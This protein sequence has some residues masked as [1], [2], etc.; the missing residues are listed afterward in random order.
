[1][2]HWPP[3]DP[4]SPIQKWAKRA[5]LALVMLALVM[6]LWPAMGS[7]RGAAFRTQCR[8]NLMTIDAL[9]REYVSQ[10]G[11]LPTDSA[12]RFSL[13][14]LS[15]DTQLLACPDGNHPYASNPNMTLDVL[16]DRRPEVPLVIDSH[17]SHLES[18]YARSWLL[19]EPFFANILCCDGEVRSKQFH[20]QAE[21]DA[22]L[23]EWPN[24][25]MPNYP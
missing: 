2:D 21:L 12:G 14:P 7:A 16:R 1:M 22:Y 15:D 19:T 23:Q 13:K 3:P 4:I 5:L 17:E 18:W 25:E 9:L 24:F 10:T 20:N 6:L 8:Q 11:T